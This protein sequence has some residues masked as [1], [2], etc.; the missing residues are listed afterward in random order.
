M[1]IFK[2]DTQG[3]AWCQLDVQ[4]YMTLI[5]GLITNSLSVCLS[6]RH[7]GPVYRGTE[8]AEELCE[9]AKE[10]KQRAQRDA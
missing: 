2:L 9:A 8:A 10:T 5:I 4:L 7:P 6:L 3:M 1:A